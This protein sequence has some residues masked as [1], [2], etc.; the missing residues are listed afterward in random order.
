M[1][2]TTSYVKLFIL[3][4]TLSFASSSSGLASKLSMNQK[5]DLLQNALRKTLHSQDLK[6]PDLGA[7]AKHCKACKV[8]TFYKSSIT[9]SELALV[10]HYCTNVKSLYILSCPLI[11]DAGLKPFEALQEFEVDDCQGITDTGF[12]HLLALTEL[13]VWRLPNFTGKKL[14]NLLYLTHLE[15]RSCPNFTG[16]ILEDL[17][18][19]TKLD[20]WNCL[21]FTGNNL[22]CL[23]K[24]NFSVGDCPQYIDKNPKP[25][26]DL[27]ILA[28]S[29]CPSSSQPLAPKPMLTAPYEKIDTANMHT[30][31]SLSVQDYVNLVNI[32]HKSKCA[33]PLFF[34]NLEAFIEFCKKITSLY[35]YKSD[36]T[37]E[38][39]TLIA[40]Y[41]PKLAMV[42]F[43]SCPVVTSSIF[44]S[45][46]A[47][48][49]LTLF[50]CKDI[51]DNGFQRLLNLTTLY[52]SKCLNFTGSNLNVL[53]NLT[54]LS[55][56][57]CAQFTCQNFE[58]FVAL[59]ELELASCKLLT[60]KFNY[61]P[62]LRKFTVDHFLE[63]DLDMCPST[64]T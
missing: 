30:T 63:F 37:D 2:T 62:T 3:A 49:E 55:V 42:T 41:L 25:L 8:L 9:D 51:T 19:L 52:I 44:K 38:E 27:P 21:N 24:L 12:Q 28:V 1:K 10:A 18:A 43:I 58:F 5:I 60:G 32:L 57:N 39:L 6:F 61:A 14:T 7:L 13:R 47:L 50:D 11:T 64:D 20:V 54:K 29:N 33:Q 36:I 34:I 22:H 35:F 46:P 15:V 53:P 40:P 59:Q 31:A 48:K 45:F 17:S 4:L 56:I 16:K 23:L 26:Q